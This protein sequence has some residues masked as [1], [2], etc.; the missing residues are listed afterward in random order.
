MVGGP[1]LAR[2][3]T[4]EEYAPELPE[5]HVQQLLCPVCQLWPAVRRLAP[6]GEPVF[7]G[8]TGEKVLTELRALADLKEWHAAS[9]LGPHS[10]GRGAA[11]A[12][13]G[14]GDS[15]PSSF[16]R[17]SG[18]PRLIS[19]TWIWGMRSPGPWLRC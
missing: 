2:S 6:E 4:R 8:W 7:P 17:A 5:L 9:R 1:R 3:C 13:L 19:F 14:A 18:I 15:S 11:R 12:I 10:F 16:A